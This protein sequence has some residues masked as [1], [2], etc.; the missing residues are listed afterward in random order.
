ML[1]IIKS[2]L[3]ANMR[4]ISLISNNIANSNTTA[5]KKSYSNFSDIYSKNIGD[6]PKAFSGMG[7]INDSP[8][9][10]MFQGPLK[11]TNGA[12]D[13]A[14]SGLGF[15]TLSS[16][17]D[18]ENRFYTRDGS[19]G[20]SSNGEIINQLKLEGRVIAVFKEKN[21]GQCRLGIKTKSGVQWKNLFEANCVLLN[22][23]KI[24]NEF[25]L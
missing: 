1:N 23:F 24:E 12:L 7:V 4:G 5:F 21:L 15:L 8:R 10:Q 13:L 6:N 2:S 16:A 9:K 19:L 14:I 20:L 17:N 18:N 11:Q 25:T 3:N 22:E